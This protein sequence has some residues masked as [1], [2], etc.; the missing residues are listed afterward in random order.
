MTVKVTVNNQTVLRVIGVTLAAVLLLA[1]IYTTR[2][3]LVLI[4][5]SIF[6]AMALNPP[7]SYLA[8]RLPGNSRGVATAISYLVVLSLIGFIIF[9]TVPPLVRQSNQLIDNIPTYIEEVRNGEGFAGSVVQQYDLEDKLDELEESF[10]PDQLTAASGPI[11]NF[12]SRFTD[13]AISTLTVLVLTFFMLVEGPG[14]VR[15][16]W[17]LHPKDHRKH[18][19]E[20]AD[21]MYSVVTGYVNGQLLIAFIAGMS[22]LIALTI[23]NLFGFGIPFIFSLAAIVGLFGLIPLIGATLGAA[24]VVLVAL[25]NSLTAAIIMLVFFVI[26]QQIEN[27]AIQP[28]IQARSVNLSPLMILLAAIIGITWAGL[29]GAIFAIPVAASLRILALDYIERN[30]IGDSEKKRKSSRS[31]SK[32]AVA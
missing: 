22:T 4:A 25:F 1:A 20:L 26:Y 3:A 24:I 11:F 21:K 9:A 12:F 27:N 31:K 10:S 29:L 8:S 28:I 15:K 19:R 2:Q 13:S 23:L 30:H 5:V 6:L 14:W 18:R 17:D 16:F 32:K 7:V